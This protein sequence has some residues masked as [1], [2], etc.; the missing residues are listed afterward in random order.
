MSDFY[1]GRTVADSKPLLYD[2]RD[3]VTHGVC[4]GMT[5]SGKTGLCIDLL[6]EALLADVPL[7]LIDPK[8]DVTNL[9]LVFP[10][11]A[12]EDFAKWIDPDA[13]RRAGRSPA[14]EGA[15]QAKLWRDGLTKWSVPLDSLR[16]LREG[17]AWRVFSPG[18]RIAR[19]VNVL[20]S[21]GP[22]AGLDW[23]R[24]EEALRDEIRGLVVALLGLAGIDADPV[25]DARPILLSRVV[26]ES[27]K[28][29][30][31]LDLA[32]LVALVENP[33]FARVGAV[34]LDAFLPRDKRRQLSLALNNLLASPDFESWREGEPLDPVKLA[35]GE[36]DRPACNLFYLA[37]L[38]DRERMFFVSRFLDRLW[39]WTRTQAGTTELRALLYFDEVMGFLPPV[40][41][42]ASKRPLLS[43]LKQGRAF[44]VG[45]LLVTQNPVDLDYKALT[46]A[47][48]WLVGR[49]QA[50]RDKE[51]LLDGLESAGIGMSRTQV[52]KTISGLEKRKFLLHDV[53]RPGGPVVF[54][55]RWARAYLRGPLAPRE[56]PDLA[57]LA[58][59]KEAEA[60]HEP[61]RA[62]ASTSRGGAPVPPSLDPVFR[63]VHV[64][65]GAPGRTLSGEV[66]ALVE[67][68]VN[69]QRPPVSG[70]RR[71]L[72]RF[73]SGAAPVPVLEEPD[74]IGKPSDA[75]PPGVSYGPL[76]SWAT[77]TNAA[78]SLERL[79]RDAVAAEGLDLDS[80]AGLG[81]T[82]NPE[83]TTE[84]FEARVRSGIDAELAKRTEKIRA[85]LS[86]KLDSLQRRIDEEMRELERDRAEATR[87]KTYS[88][89]DV[90]SSI[91]TSVLGGRRSSLGSAG[92]AGARA[93]GRIQRSAENVKE[94]EKKIADWTAERD[95]LSAE[96]ER[97]TAAERER[98]A[99]EA[100]RRERIR[101][102]VNRADVRPLEWYVL[103]S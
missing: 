1:L 58:G 66:A 84:A 37:H 99:A 13:A 103:W 96:L 42:P 15:A 44:G 52:D 61:A 35:R 55:T 78:A 97:A 38:D 69:R 23:S 68:R 83:E 6:E 24:D 30:R 101:V 73:G 9:L 40:A 4:V 57:A 19:P 62:P 100:G 49:L 82:R 45:S 72:V 16:K 43:L 5:G 12:P 26:E 93:Y 89:I 21:L 86:R 41:E 54:E 81:L 74:A 17:T 64:G 85:P 91:L 46:N 60:P 56:L 51:R 76:P 70:V 10:D 14:E 59:G 3:L 80:V 88:A 25:S 28:G 79:A 92:R 63:H 87:S 75:E 27:W 95:S 90:G 67:A 102:P 18:S 32:G 2:S 11:L 65:G 22:P 33:P 31:P 39:S 94:S 29:G 20:G 47:G 53:H 36:S 98:L 8:G 34:E 71:T 50:E 7:F 48:T 77:K